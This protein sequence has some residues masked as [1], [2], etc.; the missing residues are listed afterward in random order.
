MMAGRD[1]RTHGMSARGAGAEVRS[2]TTSASALRP[3]PPGA[4][5]V[6]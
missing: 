2:G 1:A 4:Y 3:G 5:H 6:R